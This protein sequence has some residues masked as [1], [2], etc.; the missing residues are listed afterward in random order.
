MQIVV[1][2]ATSGKEQPLARYIK[3]FLE[4]LG[5]EASEDG[6]AAHSGG[7]SGNLICKLG[8]GGDTA[9]LAHMDTARSTSEL[10]P[11]VLPDRIVSSGDTILG[12]DNRVGVALILHAIERAVQSPGVA[13]EFTAVFTVCE[14][15]T[16]AGSQFVQLPGTITSGF[17]IDTSLRPG[18]FINAT[19]GALSFKI[20]VFG[21]AAH[22][23]LEPELGVNA[24]QIAG[25]AISQIKIGRIN[26]DLIVNVAKISGG[27]AL[28]VVP[29]ATIVEGE[30]RARSKSL[31]KNSFQEME[32]KF[33]SAAEKYSGTVEY[34]YEWSFHPYTVSEKHPVYQRLTAAISQAGLEPVSHL[35]PGGSDANSLNEKGI[36]TINIGIGAQKPHSNDEFI[37]LQDFEAA[38]RIIANLIAK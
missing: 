2:N 38:S 19:Y 27:E 1:I 4:D 5:L 12:A 6:V 20:T 33:K 22:S 35:S 29:A 24:I 7:N 34:F 10:V 3:S 31:A 25:E 28:N 36:P 17:A 37:L 18:N 30:I 8:S 21:K 26:D 9:L 11:K 15:T 16:M 23:G 13:L 14:E 32:S